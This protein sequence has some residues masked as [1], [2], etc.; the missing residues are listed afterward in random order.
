M[1]QPYLIRPLT[2]DDRPWVACLLTQ[3]WGAPLIVSRGRVHDASRLPGFA[4]VYQGQP[5]GLLTYHLA[6][7]DCEIVSLDSLVERIGIGAG[8][9]A[10]VQQVAQGAGCRRLWLITT[11][12]NL[13]ALR[14]Y[15]KRG[16]CLVAVHVNALA[17][18][19]RLKPQIPLLGLDGIPLRDELE[20]ELL[21]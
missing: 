15:Q 19:R 14:F 11:N 17:E 1:D 8:L 18:A 21:L 12:D 2:L 9:I 6:G 10:A 20:L 16:F 5:A 3:N 13:P 4:A 7:S